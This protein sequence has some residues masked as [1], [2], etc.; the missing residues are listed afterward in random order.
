MDILE[1]SWAT[2][3]ML[4]TYVHF[5]HSLDHVPD[6]KSRCE[7]HEEEFKVGGCQNL[8]DPRTFSTPPAIVG[9]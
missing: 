8:D 5:L 3:R 4:M 1:E 6:S 9:V 2:E 7:T